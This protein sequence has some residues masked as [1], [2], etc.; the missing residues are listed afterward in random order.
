MLELINNFAGASIG[1]Y[2]I[3]DENIFVETIREPLV[4][5]DGFTHDYNWH[6][7][8]G[9]SNKS[10]D[11]CAVKIL[12]NCREAGQVPVKNAYILGQ[13]DI[14]MD[15]FPLTGIQ[16]FTDTLKKY[17]IKLVLEKNETLYISNTYFRSPQMLENIFNELSKNPNCAK[18]IYGGSL[19]GRELTAYLYMKENIYNSSKPVFLITSGFHPMEADTFATQAIMEYLNSEKGNE[20]LNYFNFVIIPIVNPDGFYH[21]FN[22]CNAKGV[23]LYWDFRENDKTE[24]PESCCLWQY[25]IK[26][27]PA[28]YIDFHS[29]TFQLDRKK[30]SPYIKPIYFYSGK[31]VK[32]TIRLLNDKL[33]ALH[34]GAFLTGPLTYAPSTLTYKLTRKFNTIT[35]AKYHLHIAEGKEAFKNKATVIIQTV[36]DCMLKT[37]LLTKEDILLEPYG[38]IRTTFQE[39]TKRNFKK[40]A[41]VLR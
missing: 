26:I 10:Q 37:G 32:E 18:I 1:K 20:L 6:F 23:N 13:R 31:K 28:L 22:G 16:A 2:R 25:L 3:L 7:V 17:F 30:A 9:V 41:L 33:I 21:G 38:R 8:F 24:T 19:E 14:H 29:Y 34:D 35:Y 5:K 11:S 36:C 4:K 15:F 27:R 39:R 12:I 40:L